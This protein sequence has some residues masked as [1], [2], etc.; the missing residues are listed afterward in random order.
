MQRIA[1]RASVSEQLSDRQVGDLERG[2]DDPMGSA[3]AALHSA[4]SATRE[5]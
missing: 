4:D 1:E 5:A 2:A 3:A